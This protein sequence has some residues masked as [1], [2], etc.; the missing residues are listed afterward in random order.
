MSYETAFLIF[1][2]A[3][4]LVIGSF[5]NVCIYR[6]PR[7]ES[8]AW[9]ASHCPSCNHE[10]G[11]LDLVPVVS[12][13]FLRTR[14]RYCRAPI[15]WRYPVVEAMT[16]GLFVA[17]WLR[18]GA[19]WQFVGAAVF[20]SLGIIISMIDF[21]LK[22]IPDVIS[23]PGIAAG[24]LLA[25]PSGVP[26]VLD[27]AIGAF[28]GAAVLFLVVLITPGGMGGGD[29]KLMGLIGAFLGWKGALGALFLGSFAG[30]VIG[31]TLIAFKVIKRKDPIP[32]GP[33]LV[34]GAGIFLFFSAPILGLAGRLWGL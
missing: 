32:F 15:H 29:A 7:K 30:A 31:L 26:T 21:K 13:L 4:G 8:L 27:S 16:S 1:V 20:L 19:T 33:F 23:L 3:T 28:A 24:L 10:L 22:I 6:I 17:A 11:L 5:L 9:P 14:C 25:I 18:F 34:V 2:A 12:Y